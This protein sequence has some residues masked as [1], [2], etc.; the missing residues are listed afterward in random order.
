MLVSSYIV[1]TYTCYPAYGSRYDGGDCIGSTAAASVATVC[2]Y[3]REVSIVVNDNY[4]RIAMLERELTVYEG[5]ADR[6][7]LSGS[8]GCSDEDE[9]A[10]LKEKVSKLYEYI[11]D[12]EKEVK[13]LRKK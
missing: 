7:S 4:D 13:E 3:V 9:V 12:L 5:E 11:L 8:C 10:E 2:H 6:E 1:L